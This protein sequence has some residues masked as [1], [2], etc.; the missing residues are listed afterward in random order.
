MKSLGYKSLQARCTR[1]IRCPAK[2][3]V[4]CINP[5]RIYK[6][7]VC[8]D[9]ASRALFDNHKDLIR[10]KGKD[11]ISENRKALATLKN[12]YQDSRLSDFRRNKP[13]AALSAVAGRCKENQIDSKPF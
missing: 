5:F 12:T 13:D 1:R 11:Q 3:V 4:N 2:N 8:P 9:Y 6:Q 10:K 7:V